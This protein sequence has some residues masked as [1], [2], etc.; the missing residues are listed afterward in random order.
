MVAVI[1]SVALTGFYGTPIEVET[2]LRQG[3]PSFQIVGMG[4]K[5]IN[6]AK[7]RVRSAIRNAGLDFPTRKLTVN[8]APAEIPKDGTHLDL[9]IAL[10]I[11]VASGQIKQKEVN[12]MLFVGELALDGHLRGIRGAVTAAEGARHTQKQTIFVPKANISQA[13]L[14]PNITVMGVESLVELFKHLRGI[15]PLPLHQVSTPKTTPPSPLLLDDVVGQD[16]AKRA[17]I[18]AAAGQ[19]NILLSGPPGTGKS[20]LAKRLHSLLPSLEPDARLEATKIHSLR[21]GDYGRVIT[22]P[23][24]R[25]PHHS[26]TVTSVIG[27]GARPQPGEI[28]LAHKGILFFDEL[29]EYPRTI[30]EALRQPLEDRQINIS[31]THEQITYPADILF[32]ATMNP[33]PCGYADDTTKQCTCT[34]QQIQT[35]QKKL[36]GPLLDRIDIFSSVKKVSLDSVV[37]DNTSTEKQ[38]SSALE[39]IAIA[40]KRQKLRYKSCSIY[41]AHATPE[42]VRSSLGI[43][44]EATRFAVSAATKLALST[45]SY[46]RLLRVARTIA[47]LTDQDFVKSEHVAEALQFRQ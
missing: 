17:L 8:L 9:P 6:E 13:Q 41:N 35:Y 44:P 31:R 28:S 14:V 21:F 46:Y 42:Q 45:R 36:S 33:C 27:G 26:S 20:M 5:A 24:L 43:Q 12:D 34:T 16:T 4:N 37:E 25:T 22:G 39:S 29:P 1:H 15:K 47:D 11:L 7:E 10:S 30:L 23:P 19:H 3:L 18:I 40:R 38:H 32:I 2:D